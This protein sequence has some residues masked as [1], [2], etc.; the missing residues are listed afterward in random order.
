VFTG[1]IYV[2]GG[3]DKGIFLNTAEMYNPE[4]DQWTFISPMLS[5]RS[6]HSCIAFDGC[7]YVIGKHLR[8]FSVIIL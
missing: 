2:T 4:T 8:L 1:K 6:S 5:I 3:K 7:V